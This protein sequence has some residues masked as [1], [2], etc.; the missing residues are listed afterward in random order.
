MVDASQAFSEKAISSR[1]ERTKPIRQLKD[2]VVEPI[3]DQP[4]RKFSEKRQKAQS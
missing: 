2:G 1:M 3:P 4:R